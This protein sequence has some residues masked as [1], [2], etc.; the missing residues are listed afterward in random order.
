MFEKGSK[1]SLYLTCTDV[2]VGPDDLTPIRNKKQKGGR[3][4]KG[5]K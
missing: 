5:K 3:E 2:A 1:R 4:K